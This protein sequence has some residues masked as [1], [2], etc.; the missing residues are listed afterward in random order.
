MGDVGKIMLAAAVA[1]TAWFGTPEQ[2]PEKGRCTPPE[3][4]CKVCDSGWACGNTCIG[5][6]KHCS[7]PKGCA[8][9]PEQVCGAN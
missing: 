3:K 4:C 1:L 7:K 9:N 5:K 2:G 6:M 8:C